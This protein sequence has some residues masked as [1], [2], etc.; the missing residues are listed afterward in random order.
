MRWAPAA[1]AA[2]VMVLNLKFYFGDFPQAAY[3]SDFNTRVTNRVARYLN[4]SRNGRQVFWVGAPRIF[5]GDPY[6]LFLS[7]TAPLNDVREKLAV[8]PKPLEKGANSIFLVLLERRDDLEVLRRHF[9]GSQEKE[10][11]NEAGQ[12][13]FV[14][15]ETEG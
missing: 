2:L 13:L 8:D 15:Y 5:G 7:Q 6:V 3:Y 1:L 11:R 12:L 4:E 9:P 10:F 14:A